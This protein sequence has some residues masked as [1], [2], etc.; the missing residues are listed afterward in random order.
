MDLRHIVKAPLVTA[1]VLLGGQAVQAQA[2][3]TV[4]H[5]L[6]IPQTFT[7]LRDTSVN[8]FGRNPQLEKKPALKR[9]GDPENLASKNS[10]I[11]KA[12]EIKGEEDLKPQKIKALKYLATIGCGCYD[13]VAQAFSDAL[14][15]CT[16]EVRY[17]AALSIKEAVG[18]QCSKCNGSCCSGDTPESKDLVEK[19]VKRA[20]ERDDKGCYYESSERVREALKEALCVCCPNCQGDYE[21]IS[22]QP[23]VTPRTDS[24]PVPPDVLPP[25]DPQTPGGT[26]P[27][28]GAPGASAASDR[29]ANEQTWD[30]ATEPAL[31][32]EAEVAAPSE[33][34]SVLAPAVKTVT[35]PARPLSSSRRTW[36]P[37]VVQTNAEEVVLEDRQAKLPPIVTPQSF[38]APPVASPHVQRLPITD[39][40]ERN[41]VAATGPIR[42][43]VA[44]V[45]NQRG[46]FEIEFSG[47]T[48][49]AKGDEILI[50]HNYLLGRE[51]TG[52]LTVVGYNG[53]HVVA[54]YRGAKTF[55][56]TLGDEAVI[57]NPG[58]GARR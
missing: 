29:Q 44:S 23:D 8:K 24:I 15:D 2:P 52:T 7:H 31:E 9:I 53:D 34:P 4:W 30:L 40:V 33:E 22:P 48:K 28:G 39:Q 41:V 18:A 13:G 42:G 21:E 32:E 26:A 55:R 49:P 51:M 37:K 58:V 10:A 35:K 38:P 11:K 27:M 20:Y 1:V 14:E 47:T 16:E 6:G 25:T 46:V 12:A 43:N 19:M 57:D 45:N 56:V 50:Y 17:V 3:P 54:Q 5:A 36:Q